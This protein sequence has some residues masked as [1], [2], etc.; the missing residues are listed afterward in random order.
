MAKGVMGQLGANAGINTFA[1]EQLL[2][3]TA[4]VESNLVYVRQVG[5]GP[6]LGVYQMEPRTHDDLWASF[7]PQHPHLMVAV[8]RVMTPQ[9]RHEQLVTNLAYATA[10]ARVMYRRVPALLPAMNDIPAMAAYWK[11]YYNTNLGKG[12]PYD[13][14][15]RAQAAGV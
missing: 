13:F 5:G 15:A 1:A 3:G 8:E 9:D 10:M 4:L 2:L 12:R 6:A 11:K 14:I 7:L